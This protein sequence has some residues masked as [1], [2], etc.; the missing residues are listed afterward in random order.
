[1]LGQVGGANRGGP[2]SLI[3]A[4][5][6]TEGENPPSEGG[7]LPSLDPDFALTLE[8]AD[9][10]LPGEEEG[11]VAADFGNV[12]GESLGEPDDTACIDDVVAADIDLEDG[13]VAVK[14]EVTLSGAL[15]E[16]EGFSRK[17]PLVRPCHLDLTTTLGPDATK[18]ALWR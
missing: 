8:S 5:D 1:M 11:F 14:P 10:A 7:D 12:V 13:S 18:A 3:A 17:K 4:L 16:E 9:E 15:D 2:W 6:R